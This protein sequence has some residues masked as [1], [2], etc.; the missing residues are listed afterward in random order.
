MIFDTLDVLVPPPPPLQV[1]ILAIVDGRRY[2][3]LGNARQMP[4]RALREPEVRVNSV[5]VPI[6]H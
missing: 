3:N 4:R 5:L 2:H 6:V 1:M